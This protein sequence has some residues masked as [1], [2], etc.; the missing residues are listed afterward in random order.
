MNKSLIITT[1]TLES[2]ELV[3]HAVGIAEEI[4]AQYVSRRKRG[5]TVLLSAYDASA[6]LIVKTN[7]LTLSDG[8]V[9]YSY[10]PNMLLVRGLNVIH[11]MRDL[12][13]EAAEIGIGDKVLD[14]TIGFGCEASLAALVSGAT[15]RVDGLESEAALALITRRGMASKRLSTPPLIEAMSRVNV[16]TADYGD[17]LE[18]T[19]EG[20]YDVVCFDPFFEHRLHGSEGSVSPLA[21]FG[22]P[23]PLSSASVVR[24]IQVA[25]RL[26]V[27]KHPEHV[28]LPDELV[29][30]R[31]HIVTSRKSKITYSVFRRGG[32]IPIFIAP[33]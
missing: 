16:I 3:E 4:G 18:Q 26:V 6:A 19:N 29:S 31:S 5:I 33:T 32:D 22:N 27:V 21:R 23:K 20:E 8:V 28:E 10:H 9:E 11:G 25:N 1:S 15:G 30:V 14:C 2:E 17:F 13:I 7:Q 24:A 12:F